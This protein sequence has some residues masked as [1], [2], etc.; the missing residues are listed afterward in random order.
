M[1]GSIQ[2]ESGLSLWR[3]VVIDVCL[4]HLLRV[5]MMTGWFRRVFFGFHQ[6]PGSVIIVLVRCGLCCVCVTASVFLGDR[7]CGVM[8]LIVLMCT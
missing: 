2:Y 8:A 6:L 5:L 4:V 1:S 3:F 7:V